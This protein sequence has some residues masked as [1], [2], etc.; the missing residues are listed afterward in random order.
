MVE[1]TKDVTEQR[2][3]KEALKA[4]SLATETSMSA[5]FTADLKGIII[6]A[7]TAAAKMWGYKSTK[8][9]IGTN[10]LEYWTKSTQGRAGEL[11]GTL[12]KKGHASS[13]GELTGKKLD[14]TEF[15]VESNSVL[16]KDE[17]GKPV[18]LIGSFSDITKR[19]E[20]EAILRSSEE[21]LKIF[22][23]SAP[24]AIFVNDLKGNFIEGNIAAEKITGYKKE[25]LIGKSFLKLNLLSLDQVAKAAKLLAKNVLGKATGPDEFILK[26]KDGTQVPVEINTYPI[27]IKGK[28]MVLGIARDIS[29][30]KIAE[31]VL[32]EYTDNLEK[33]VDERTR[34]LQEV[35]EELIR[36]ERLAVLGK[37]A[38]GIGHDLRTPLGAIKNAVYFLNMAVEKPEPDVKEMLEVIENEISISD[39]I[40]TGLL[41]FARPKI[42]KKQKVNVSDL[43]QESL[44]RMQVPENIKV[45]TILNK[46]LPHILADPVQIGQIIIN[47]IQNGFQAMPDGGT[48][49][50]KSKAVESDQVMISFSDTGV[51]ISKENLK[52]L[53]E[54]LFTTKPSGT[55][56]GLALVEMLVKEH[57]GTIQAESKKGKGSTFFV[58]FPANREKGE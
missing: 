23:E 21:R 24:D 51:G 6:Y 19:L 48:F 28:S 5:I 50:V 30:Q 20:T 38:G 41:D 53:F 22:Y 15:I 43:L 35:H 49:I 37:L 56:L 12:L 4:S 9:M 52:K 47:I 17:K 46:K 31:E 58:A 14:G 11:M 40:I 39:G 16:I 2:K 42:S 10:A 45:E 27:K 54:P 3:T 57:S 32:K 1:A 25:E 26:R 8:E 36:K 55:G 7:N 13:S 34:E 44:S 29:K 18:G 33:I